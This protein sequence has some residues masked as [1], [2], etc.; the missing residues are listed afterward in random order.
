MC[1]QRGVDAKHR[2]LA[3][4]RQGSLAVFVGA[5]TAQVG[6]IAPVVIASTLVVQLETSALPIDAENPAVYMA[7]VG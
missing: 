7:K 6:C 2:L 4:A 5:Q 3:E 1:L